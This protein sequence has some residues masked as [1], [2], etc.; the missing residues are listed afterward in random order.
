MLFCDR[1]TGCGGDI[2]ELADRQLGPDRDTRQHLRKADRDLL[3]V[4]SSAC[5]AKELGASL[6]CAVAAG[7][8]RPGLEHSTA[9]CICIHTSTHFPAPPAPAKALL[10]AI[11]PNSPHLDCTSRALN[12]PALWTFCAP[13]GVC[14]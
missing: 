12:V 10:L 1:L 7:G 3:A 14:S 6:R 5:R 11:R 4:A 8:Q 2:Q 9:S 13:D